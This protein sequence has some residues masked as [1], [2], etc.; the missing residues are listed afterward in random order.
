MNNSA[1]IE[2]SPQEEGGE[3]D[4]GDDNAEGDRVARE[5]MESTVLEPAPPPADGLRK[6]ESGVDARMDGSSTLDGMITPRP[7]EQDDHAGSMNS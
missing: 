6:G 3:E 7:T 4:K 5:L 2:E 1:P